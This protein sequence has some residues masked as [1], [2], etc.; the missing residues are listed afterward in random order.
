MTRVVIGSS[1][2][3]VCLAVLVAAVWLLWL[4]GHGRHRRPRRAPAPA[5]ALLVTTSAPELPHGTEAA[6]V[7]TTPEPSVLPLQPEVEDQEEA[8]GPDSDTV[9]LLAADRA[10]FAHC[11]AEGRRTPH[12]LHS[13]G[14]RTCCECETETAGDQ[15]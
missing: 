3:A 5:R 10:D 9:Y 4:S 14:S 12:F 7:Q 2:L 6:L 15:T 13:D 11:P 1:V 8:G